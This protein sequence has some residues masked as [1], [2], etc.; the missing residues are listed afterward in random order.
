MRHFE[1]ARAHLLFHGWKRKRKKSVKHIIAQNPPMTFFFRFEIETKAH[2]TYHTQRVGPDGANTKSLSL[3]PQTD[4]LSLSLSLAHFLAVT[5]AELF[6]AM[7]SAKYRAILLAPLLA[8]NTN[9]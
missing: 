6:K 8:V 7:N 5:I 2:N 3:H 9:L 4:S 1:M